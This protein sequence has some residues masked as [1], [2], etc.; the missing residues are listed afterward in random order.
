VR[1][2]GAI[3]AA[4]FAAAVCAAAP[5]ATSKKPVPLTVNDLIDVL[6]TR[7]ACEATVGTVNLK[8]KKLVGCYLVDE[9]GAP[10][11]GSFAP[12]LA[13]DGEI[14]IVK[15]AKKPPVVF[16]RTL[17]SAGTVRAG[18]YL[19][20]TVGST[21]ALA[22]TDLHCGVTRGERGIAASCFKVTAGRRSANTY[23]FAITNGAVSILRVDASHRPHTVHVQPEPKQA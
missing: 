15:V 16:G 1:P 2:R 12:A 3:V 11:I 5:A 9:K 4:A 8:G 23:G 19:M 18:R 17:A 22:G 20:A 10:A 21:F 14:V 7:I 6:D 13:V